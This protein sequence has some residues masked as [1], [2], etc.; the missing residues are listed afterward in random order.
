MKLRQMSSKKDFMLDVLNLMEGIPF[1]LVTTAKRIT[2]CFQQGGVVVGILSH[3][4]H[5]DT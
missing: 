1:L 2:S 4:P 5:H 3:L